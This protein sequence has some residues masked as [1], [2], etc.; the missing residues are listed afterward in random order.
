MRI[1]KI[2]F[3]GHDS[4]GS[5]HMFDR[6]CAAFPELEKRV[7][8][9]TGLY[10]R[11]STSASILKL[12]RESSILFCAVRAVEMYWNKFRGRTLVRRIKKDNIEHI[13]TD[14]IN[15]PEAVAFAKDFA[16]DLLVS[17]YTMHIYKRPILEVPKFGAINSH[18]AILPEYRGLEVFFWAM[19]NGES[20]IGSSVFFLNERVDDGL[21]LHERKL[22][23]TTD[24]SM[25]D[26]YNA[27]TESAADFLIQAIRGIDA[28]KY[29]TRKP[30]GTGSYYPMPTRA[31]VRAFR[32]RGYRFF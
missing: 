17:L 31:A 1:R 27:I 22:P 21:I 16:P 2:L 12:V 11:K 6:I 28:E 29:E 26:V 23:I 7:I 30:E 24:H 20:E 14:D 25:T 9:T 13:F 19:A 10:Y 8:V 5:L 18:P 3:C 4:A 15:G 32:R